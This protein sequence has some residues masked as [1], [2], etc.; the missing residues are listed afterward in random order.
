MHESVVQPK[1]QP[2]LEIR[3]IKM[4]ICD[5]ENE[6]MVDCEMNKVT[7]IRK[8]KIK[9]RRKKNKRAHMRL[10]MLIVF[11]SMVVV[12]VCMCVSVGGFQ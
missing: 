7:K 11:V 3:M 8:C 1:H 12:C 5:D 2:P 9:E 10:R 4:N 6:Q